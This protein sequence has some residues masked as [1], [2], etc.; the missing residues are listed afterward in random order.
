MLFGK[1]VVVGTLALALGA[2]LLSSGAQV[3]AGPRHGEND[4]EASPRTYGAPVTDPAGLIDLPEGF[5]YDIIM[6]SGDLMTDGNPYPGGPD[7]N[8]YFPLP[9]GTAYLLTNH[10]LGGGRGS[11]TRLHLDEDNRVLEARTLVI[12]LN[13]PCSGN[14]TPW[15]TVLVGEEV[16]DGYVWEINPVTGEAHPRPGLGRFAHE[17]AV[18]DPRTGEV[19][20]TDDN[21]PGSIYK[22]VPARYG[23]LGKGTLYALDAGH[24]RWIRIEN[25]DNARDEAVAKG[26]TGFYRPEDAEFGRDGWLYVTITGDDRKGIWGKVIKIHPRNLQSEDFVTGS[27]D[28]LNM[29]DNLVFDKAGNLYIQEDR[30]GFVNG[31]N[32]VWVAQ[33]NGKVRPFAVIGHNDEPSGGW[34]SPDGETLYLNLMWEHPMT[35]AIKGF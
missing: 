1:H 13:R 22:F 12:G 2:S 11:V 16:S 7:M 28:G 23:D 19:Y 14:R 10:E 31:P 34:F 18:V 26:A 27:A 24:R 15:G 4:R 6:Q 5:S 30:S 25:P 32:H 35:L 8:V 20:T 33:P 9:D 17:T 29:P 3:L 21:N